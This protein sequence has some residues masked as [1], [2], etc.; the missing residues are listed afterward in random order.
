MSFKDLQAL[1]NAFKLLA[2]ENRLKIVGLLKTRTYTVGELAQTL[3]IKEP[4]V[5]HHLGKLR[6]LGVVNLNSV[7]NFHQY[8]LNEGAIKRLKALIVDFDA[9]AMYL[10]DGSENA[11]IDELTISDEDKKVLRDYTQNGRLKQIPVKHKK[12]IIILDWISSH[13]QAE[14][15][16]TEA[17]VN[18][19]IRRFH[20]DHATIRRGLVDLGY[21]RRER[22]GGKYWVTPADEF[23]QLTGRPLSSLTPD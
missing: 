5:S 11:W 12:F 18:E 9:A 14:V 19:I 21:L 20:D 17:E 2:D 22:G 13:F 7:G 8:S 6:E 23:V 10:D 4:T 15:F 16:Y 1:I 3:D